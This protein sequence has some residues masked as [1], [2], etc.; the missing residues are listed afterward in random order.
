[1]SI[2]GA[3]DAAEPGPAGQRA[4][5]GGAATVP[6]VP[7][8]D[9]IRET[10]ERY[11]KTFSAG[12]REGWLDLFT[13][14]ATIEDPVGSDVCRGRDEIGGFWDRSRAAADHITLRLV[15]GPGGNDR[16]A[17]FAM[18]AHAE[19][20]GATM[21]VPTIDVMTF[22]DDGRIASQR[23]FWHASGVRTA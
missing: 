14:D 21:I 16:E 19:L 12:D 3:G 5:S 9:Q 8:E 17:A 23:A 20:G 11:L 7:S 15:Q 18:E 6:P 10:V 4:A 1:M 22:A 2:G 13:A